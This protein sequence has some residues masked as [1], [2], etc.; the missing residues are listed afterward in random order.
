M[1]PALYSSAANAVSAQVSLPARVFVIS[2]SSG[3]RQPQSMDA[4]GGV[5]Y[6]SQGFRPV[7]KSNFRRH[8]RDVDHSKDSLTHWLISTRVPGS[9]AGA[10][11]C[12]RGRT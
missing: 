4:V 5:L 9:C 7:W 6:L 8:Q 3:F 11:R 10:A 2:S 12:A 1:T